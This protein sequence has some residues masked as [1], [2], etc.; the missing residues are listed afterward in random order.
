[1]S[2]D[3]PVDVFLWAPVAV[4][5]QMSLAAAG[6]LHCSSS[7]ALAWDVLPISALGNGF[8]ACS[9]TVSWL[10][11]LPVFVLWRKEHVGRKRGRGCSR[12]PQ[13]PHLC[14]E[15]GEQGKQG[16]PPI[17][18]RE[19]LHWLQRLLSRSPFLHFSVKNLVLLRFHWGSP[20]LSQYQPH[21]SFCY[22]EKSRILLYTSIASKNT[23]IALTKW[24]GCA[25]CCDKMN[26]NVTE[27]SEYIW[28]CC[29]SAF[30][31]IVSFFSY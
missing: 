7:A 9:N 24:E 19:C 18:F 27:E 17:V 16:F 12:S 3:L 8:S 26:F 25:T 20:Q 1:M 31:K 2:R 10:A 4:L 29:S 13:Q 28:L 23:A 6:A 5:T 22:G 14:S 15:A 30:Y 11:D 21:V